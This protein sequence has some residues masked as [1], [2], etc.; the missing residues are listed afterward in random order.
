VRREVALLR[1]PIP[2]CPFPAYHVDP[3]IPKAD[4]MPSI[5]PPNAPFSDADFERLDDLLWDGA[6][7]RD[8]MN[9]EA[10]D[11]FFSA[12]F[13]SPVQVDVETLLPAIWGGGEP[14]F[15]DA[16]R[17]EELLALLRAFWRSVGRRIAQTNDDDY[18]AHIPAIQLSQ[19]V[20]EAVSEQRLESLEDDTPYGADWAAGFEYGMYLH[21][22]EWDERLETDPEL[23]DAISVI[24]ALADE[25][26]D[27][28]EDGDD[29]DDEEFEDADA[30]ADALSAEDFEAALKDPELARTAR[31]IEQA[32]V[33][34]T[35]VRAALD[36][37]MN[38]VRGGEPVP[39]SPINRESLEAALQETAEE[40]D[41][42]EEAGLEDEDDFDPAEID[43]L[44]EPLSAAERVQ[45][46][47]ELPSVLLTLHLVRLEEQKPRPAR[48]ESEVGRN[49]P[50]PCGS[51]KKYKKCHGAPDALH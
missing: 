45:L 44:L 47:S 15:E 31:L 43:E 14:P 27:E 19:E 6:V 29:L 35:Q 9:L 25:V 12:L 33:P 13:V 16:A 50:C 34:D 36:E 48:R 10:V 24:F 51:G 37:I 40:S 23:E 2:D 39:G 18:E 11:G 17:N 30:D 41:F 21:Q 42:D 1:F 49:D 38:V 8:G 5:T 4:T 20:F 3:S 46:I 7:P 26:E 32:G 28:D 22:A